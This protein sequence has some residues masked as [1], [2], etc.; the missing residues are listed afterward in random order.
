MRLLVAAAAPVLVAP[1]APGQ[2]LR[3]A[4]PGLDA[5]VTAGLKLWKVPG[6]SLA[7]V[8]NDSVI[9]AK[10]Y[11]VRELGKPARV[12][13]RTVF[14][15]GSS[16]KAFTAA[17]VAMLVDEKKVALDAPAAAY[18][19]G[20]Q[21]FDP[22]ASRELTVRDLLTHR[23]GLGTIDIL[24]YASPNSLDEI[25]R[26]LHRSQG[27]AE[28][29]LEV[30]RSLSHW[31]RLGRHWSRHARCLSPHAHRQLRG[32]CRARPPAPPAA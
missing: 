31:A 5:Y 19:P 18:L 15:I 32:A 3:E 22:Y 13:E 23:S 27:F 17:A 28:Q 12:T 7:I 26:R 21:L 8:R 4:Y 30:G 10:G 2:T 14:A 20:F 6:V 16:S 29:H 1:P 9:Y 25:V 11:G 24:W